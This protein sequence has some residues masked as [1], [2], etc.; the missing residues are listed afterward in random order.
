MLWPRLSLP[1]RPGICWPCPRR[2][3]VAW[4][5]GTALSPFILAGSVLLK[6]RLVRE[7]FAQGLITSHPQVRVLPGRRDAAWGAI[8]LALR[9][10]SA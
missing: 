4:I 3:S 2:L 7:A 1:M 10:L 8:Y 6:S 5:C 9:Q